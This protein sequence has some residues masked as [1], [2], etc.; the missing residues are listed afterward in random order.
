MAIVNEFPDLDA[1]TQVAGIAASADFNTLRDAVEYLANPPYCSV[2]LTA[3]QSVANAS[4]HT[5]VWDESVDDSHG[6]MWDVGAPSVLTMTRAGVMGFQLNQLWGGS[7]DSGKRAAFLEKTSGGVTTRLR[8]YQMPA[9]SPSEMSVFFLTNVAALDSVKI[10]TR[11]L[12]GAA[13]NMEP[14]RTVMIAMW[15]RKPPTVGE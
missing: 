8:G 7:T 6:D 13:L 11:Q 15:M 3:L 14:L 1:I 2:R 10:V 12:S 4:D 9:V 5:I